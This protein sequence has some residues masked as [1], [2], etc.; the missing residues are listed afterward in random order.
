MVRCFEND[1]IVHVAGK[2]DPLNDIEVINTE[3][4]LADMESVE[5]AITKTSKVAK[6]GDKDAKARLAVLEQ[7]QR[8]PG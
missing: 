4:A 2:I 3:L 7:V 5:K 8:S 6:S 1:D